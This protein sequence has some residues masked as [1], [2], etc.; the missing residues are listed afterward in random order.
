MKRL[1]SVGATLTLACAAAPPA[2]AQPGWY[3][4]ASFGQSRTS[5]DLVANRE[6]TITGGVVDV[7]SDFD[8]RDRTMKAVFNKAS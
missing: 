2:L 6:S 5:R 1:A 4:G 8:A 7:H 3:A